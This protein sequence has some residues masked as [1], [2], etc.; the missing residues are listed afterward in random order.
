M[1]FRRISILVFF[2]GSLILS[3]SPLAFALAPAHEILLGTAKEEIT[4]PLGTPLAGFGKRHGHPSMDVFDPL[5]A[6]ALSLSY[7]KKRFVFVSVDLV[8][9]DRNLRKA[10]LKKIRKEIPLS[11]DELVLFATHTH[12]G[13]GSIGKSLWER[14]IMGGFDKD[15]FE[16]ITRRIARA[17]I[18]SLRRLVPVISE[19]AAVRI[20]ED[21]ENRMDSKLEDADWLK[22]LRFKD[23]EGN[24]RGLMVFMA[25]HP[26]MLSADNYAF[27]ADY[28]G[29]LTR[30]LEEAFP[31]AVSLFVNGAAADLRPHTEPIKDRYER[32]Q[33]YG[34]RLAR[35]VLEMKFMP[36]RLDGLWQSSARESQLPYVRLRVGPLTLPAPLG[37]RIFPTWSYFHALRLGPALF[38]MI[39]GELASEIGRQIET[40]A[41]RQGFHPFVVGY[42]N[43][44]LGY[45][46]PRRYYRDLS[47]YEAKASFYGEKFAWFVQKQIDLLIEDLLTEEEKAR[48]NPPGELFY[49]DALPVL[50]LKGT[51]YH[52]GYEEG[53]LLGPQIRKGV[54]EIFNYLR[55][56]L[57]LVG[58]NRLIFSTILGRAWKKMEP[59][60]SYSEYEQMRGLAEGAGI[61]FH[62]IKKI[63]ALPEVYPT[64]CSNGAYWGRA[65]R[66]GKLIAIRNLDWNRKIG[67]HRH[68]AVK[69]YENQAGPDYVNIGYYGFIGVLSGLNEKGISVGQIGATSADETMEGVP[70]PFLLRR[71]LAKASSLEEAIAILRQSDRTRGYNYVIASASEKKAVAVEATQHHLAVFSD[72]DPR[73]K[74]IP[75]ALA[76]ENAVFRGDPALDPAIRNLQWASNGN[77]KQPGLEMPT[78][79]AYEIRYLKHG[80]L[81]REYYG[82]ID[83]AMA[84]DIA[85]KIA[86]GSNIQSVVYAF[87]EFY[88]ANAQGDQKAAESGYVRF[89]FEELASR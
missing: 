63:H 61:P 1:P 52:V 18:H 47:Q 33:V 16:F 77:P 27:S 72:A 17:A 29:F 80:Q 36:L 55:S 9:I 54:S 43:D 81:V 8:L 64:W 69:F 79:S 50:K 32:T 30:V 73:E 28:P 62:T 56:E 31:D 38:V 60:I 10:V 13:A 26:T 49:R 21:V 5:Y 40:R 19:F 23:H 74:E 41:A 24:V 7:G 22:A 82:K 11:E 66:T 2:I 85:R 20:D 12:S 51:P 58:I 76:V 84:Q 67:I 70:M 4:P 35:K 89:H 48:V 44:Y 34:Q 59:Y 37:N 39:P 78:G 53:R 14:F 45:I 42:A 71:I 6:R 83:V 25:A 75:Y 87:P 15:N 3:S 68:A 57:P 65:T 88:V 46:V 86:P